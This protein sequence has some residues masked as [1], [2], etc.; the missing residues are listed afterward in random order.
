MKSP[1]C[2]Q[3]GP[4]PPWGLVTWVLLQLITFPHHRDFLDG[5][6]DGGRSAMTTAHT[7]IYF[8]VCKA[9]NLYSLILTGK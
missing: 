4:Q 7:C 6:H 5:L 8:Y 1:T 9:D 3:S 2:L